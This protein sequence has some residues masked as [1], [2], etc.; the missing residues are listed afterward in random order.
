MPMTS[1][2][3]SCD[4]SNDS[5][6][7]SVR[8]GS[9]QVFGMAPARTNIQRGVMTAM[10]NDRSLGLTMWTRTVDSLPHTA[11]ASASP[12]DNASWLR[13]ARREALVQVYTASA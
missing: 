11:G 3:A 8:I 7:S 2:A 5:S 10:P 12:Q 13:P 6:V 1:P 4:G 9:P